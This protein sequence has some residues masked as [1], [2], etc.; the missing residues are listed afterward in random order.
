MKE[1]AALD[2]EGFDLRGTGDSSGTFW[3]GLG[4]RG[5]A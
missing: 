2:H 1:V 3:V 5:A 4:G